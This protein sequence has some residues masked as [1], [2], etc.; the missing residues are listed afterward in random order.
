[1]KI[2]FIFALEGGTWA[3]EVLDV[4]DDYSSAEYLSPQWY[5]DVTGWMIDHPIHKRV[6]YTGVY[7]AEPDIEVE[8]SEENCR[9]PCAYEDRC[10]WCEEYWRRMVAED[11]FNSATFQWT[12]LALKEE[13]KFNSA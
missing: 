13:T 1:M 2:E 12:R 3:T 7:N 11:L 6:L 10:A 8:D 9:K 5:D 4:P